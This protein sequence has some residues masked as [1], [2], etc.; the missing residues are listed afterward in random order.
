M[1]YAVKK[2]N[3]NV[4]GETFKTATEGRRAKYQIII[5]ARSF[6]EASPFLETKVVKVAKKKK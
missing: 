4:L 3:R 6:K 2:G 5:G 1:A